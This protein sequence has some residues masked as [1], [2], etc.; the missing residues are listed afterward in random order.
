MFRF[1]KGT[2]QR[3]AA[4]SAMGVKD[5]IVWHWGGARP[6][7]SARAVVGCRRRLQPPAQGRLLRAITRDYYGA[8]GEG[9]IPVPLPPPVWP[10]SSI[11]CATLLVV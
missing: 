6:G 2:C 1:G 9:S 11:L 3:I 8:R 10:Q 7:G 4:M 5:E